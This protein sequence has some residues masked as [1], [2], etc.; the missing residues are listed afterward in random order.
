MASKHS[1]P[2]DSN[3]LHVAK[4]QLPDLSIAPT[5]SEFVDSSQGWQFH[6]VPQRLA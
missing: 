2:L 6:S 1:A 4:N 3:I 5:D